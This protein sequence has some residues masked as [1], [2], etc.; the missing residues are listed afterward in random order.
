MKYKHFEI[1]FGEFVL[2]IRDTTTIMGLEHEGSSTFVCAFLRVQTNSCRK[3]KKEADSGEVAKQNATSSSVQL[4]FYFEPRGERS[5][6]KESD[7]SQR[8]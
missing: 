2:L 1:D 7:H 3:I 8:E 5:K 4:N 6:I